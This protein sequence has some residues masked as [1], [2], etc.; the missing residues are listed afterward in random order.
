MLFHINRT[1]IFT[2]QITFLIKESG[3]EGRTQSETAEEKEK[4]YQARIDEIEDQQAEE[5]AKRQD[6]GWEMVLPDSNWIS[7]VQ[8]Y[9]GYC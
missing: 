3:D 5:E 4:Q 8:P 1:Y 6:S 7:R 9:S 2:R